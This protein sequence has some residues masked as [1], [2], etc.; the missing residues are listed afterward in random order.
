MKKY[1]FRAHLC[2][3]SLYAANEGIEM[4][5]RFILKSNDYKKALLEAALWYENLISK[6]PSLRMMCKT[7]ITLVLE[8]KCNETDSE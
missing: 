8:E 4:E 3:R 7:I 6:N 5:I 1:V 2:S